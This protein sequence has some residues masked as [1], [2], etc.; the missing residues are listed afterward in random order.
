VIATR[1][2]TLYF[3]LGGLVLA[4]GTPA[5]LALTRPDLRFYLL[6][7]VVFAAQ[8]IPYL[9]AAGLWLPWRSPRATRLGQGLAAVLFVAAVLLYIPILTG[10]V[11]TGGDMVALGYLLMAMVTTVSVLCVTLVAFGTLWLRH[12]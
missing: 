6:Q 7:P 2:N 9:L 10:L 5:F 4:V 1:R 3:I 11:P 12:R 8:P